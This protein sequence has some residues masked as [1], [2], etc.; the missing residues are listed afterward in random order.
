MKVLNHVLR[1]LLLIVSLPL[2]LAQLP[3][4]PSAVKQREESRKLPFC[5]A[6][7]FSPLCI[8]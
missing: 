5:E 1:C 8:V 4:A 2:A 7:P 3:D 6:D